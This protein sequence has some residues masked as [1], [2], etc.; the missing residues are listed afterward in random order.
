MIRKDLLDGDWVT[1]YPVG[2]KNEQLWRLVGMELARLRQR[3]GFA[4]TLAITKDRRD[5]PAKNTLDD[6][7]RGRPGT[8]DKLE[9]YC[10]ALGLE[11]A[12]VMRTVLDAEHDQTVLSADAL[13]VG[14]MYQDGPNED[15]RKALRG[16]AEAQH[17][18]Q[19]ASLVAV[20]APP[21]AASAAS[22]DSRS[23]KR[24]VRGRR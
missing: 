19:R 10:T 17:A 20:P 18:L 6:I 9:G 3:A 7:E 22:G 14:R 16:A 1:T 2:V 13:W 11:L 4:S 5:V 21:V 8:I 15:L 12:A 23:S 24:T